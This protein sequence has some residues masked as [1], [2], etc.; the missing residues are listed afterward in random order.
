MEYDLEE[1]ANSL[2]LSKTHF[3]ELEQANL[4]LKNDYDELCEQKRNADREL[5]RMESTI[6]EL[7]MDFTETHQ[8]LKKEV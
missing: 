6:S 7:Q 8:Q 5:T 3:Q 2:R 4:N 1:S